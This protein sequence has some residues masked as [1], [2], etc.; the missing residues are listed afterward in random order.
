MKSLWDALVE[1]QDTAMT[2]SCHFLLARVPSRSLRCCRARF[3]RSRTRTKER[4]LLELQA[5]AEAF[6]APQPS[7]TRRLRY[8]FGCEFPYRLALRRELG[9]QLLAMGLVGAAA[10]AGVRSRVRCEETGVAF[11]EMCTACRSLSSLLH[12]STP[13]PHSTGR[14]G[15]SCSE[16]EHRW[17]Q[18]RRGGGGGGCQLL[19]SLT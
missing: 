4:A 6:D 14:A 2:E 16:T 15:L 8:A 11:A 10:A 17:T 7:V 18:L 13:P 9:E 1:V 3:E 12:S 5:L 19:G